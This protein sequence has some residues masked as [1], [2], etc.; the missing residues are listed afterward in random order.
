MPKII[1]L[2][3]LCLLCHLV[4]ST[5]NPVC[6][7]CHDIV[8]L[9]QKSV[10]KQPLETIVEDLA[11]VICAKKTSFAKNV[12]KG[13][14][15]EMTGIILNNFWLHR[16]DPHMICPALKLCSQEYQKRILKDDIAKILKGKVEKE[17]EAPTLRKTLKVMHI[18]DLHVDLFYTAGSESKCNEPTCC[19]SNSTASKQTSEI[20]AEI[21]SGNYLESNETVK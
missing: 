5:Y 9:V 20:M 7:L 16:T 21:N 13:A 4:L 17:W 10:K 12:C 3:I 2:L 18:S 8:K 14:I 15:K 1:P 11:M 6:L 19:R